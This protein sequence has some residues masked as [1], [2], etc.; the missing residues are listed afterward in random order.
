MKHLKI[1]V[2][3]KVYRVT[4]ETGEGP[5]PAANPAPAKSVAAA[6]SSSSPASGGK[7]AL[8]SPLSGSVISLDAA[9]GTPVTE[10]QKVMTLEAMKMN[11]VVVAHRAGTIRKIMVKP[12]DL[13]EEGQILMLIG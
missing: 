3:G 11:T 1:T 10:G 2:D 8:V 5:A 6:P 4:V 13:V 7:E 12:G 9:A